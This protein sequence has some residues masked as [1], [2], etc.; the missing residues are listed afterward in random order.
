LKEALIREVC[1]EACAEIEVG[2]I[3]LVYEFAP[4]KQSGNYD[5]QENHGLHIIFECDIKEGSQPKLPETPDPHQTAVKWIGVD[6][7]DSIVLIPNIQD[8]IKDYLRN[9]RNIDFIEDFRLKPL[10]KS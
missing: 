9:K 2:P 3:A 7:L 10:K 1:E 8:Q 5:V 4:H 6:E